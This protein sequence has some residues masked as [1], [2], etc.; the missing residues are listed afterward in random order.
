MEHVEVE[1]KYSD[2]RRIP[3]FIEAVADWYVKN[4]DEEYKDYIRANPDIGEYWDT[5]CLHIRNEFLYPQKYVINQEIKRMQK[6]DQDYSCLIIDSF[7]AEDL[8]GD[9]DRY[10]EMVYNKIIL[11]LKGM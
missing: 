4:L 2:Y 3:L 6:E 10:S 1:V 5:L 9:A 11:K 8:F 7:F